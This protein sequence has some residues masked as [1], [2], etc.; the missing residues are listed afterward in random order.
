MRTYTLEEKR[1]IQ[2]H[3]LWIKH[4]GNVPEELR[5]LVYPDE[6]K[7]EPEKKGKK[8]PVEEAPA[9]VAEA[10]TELVSDG[11]SN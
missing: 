5:H 3:P 4:S 11:D 9:P 7:P 8:K 1:R 2:R 6:A 10:P